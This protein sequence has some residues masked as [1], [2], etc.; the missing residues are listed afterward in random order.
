MSR[1]I[2]DKS[3]PRQRAE[4]MPHCKHRGYDIVAEHLD[5]GISGSEVVRRP[6]LQALLALAC[7]RRING[8]VVDDL[9]RLA[10]LD[11]LEIGELLS[12]LRRA[13]VWVESVA[14]GRLDYDDMG[15]RLMLGVSSEAKRGEQLAIARRTL[16]QHVRMARDEKR[17]PMTKRP[18]GYRRVVAQD[19]AVRLE[20]DGLTAEV[21]RQIFRWYAA[22]HTPGWIVAELYR[23][24]QPSPTGRPRWRRDTLRQMFANPVYAGR[25][26]WGKTSCGRFYRQRGGKVVKGAG[27][28][29]HEPRPEEEWFFTSDDVT[30]I[31]DP[32]LWASVQDRRHNRPSAPTPGAR[33]GAFLFSRLLVCAR[34]QGNMTGYVRPR[35]NGEIVYVCGNYMA[36]G[37][38]GDCPR[39]QVREKW[40]ARQVVAQLRGRLLAPERIERLRAQLR[41]YLTAQRGAERRAQLQREE[42]SLTL[43]LERA[44]GR[45][46]EVSRDMIPEVEQEIRHSREA[47]ER[48]K[49]ALREL[50]TADPVRDLDDAVKAASGAVWALEQALDGEDRLLLREALRGILVRVEV[51]PVPYTTSTG[52]TWH[53]PGAARLVL[54]PGTGLELLAERPDELPD[55]AGFRAAPSR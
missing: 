4:V 50:E 33:P 2:Q 15:G 13:G 26:A 7:S 10:R 52:K 43:R 16:T 55:V 21:V 37:K 24:C 23:R 54:R 34:C 38:A 30:P 12:P 47:L 41:E 45:L 27:V 1:D 36:H 29:K 14:Q 25:R 20:P 40:L 28:Y 19:G 22:G 44:R 48:V 8:V 9:D 49:A 11:M 35:S 17:P 39:C 5:E 6:G 53:R 31:I 32:E 42:S 18:Y 3:I 51:L 46:V